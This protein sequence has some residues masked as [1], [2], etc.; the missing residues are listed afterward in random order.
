MIKEIML[1][2]DEEEICSINSG[3]QVCLSGK[4]FTARDAAHRRL[5][6]LLEA[7]KPLPFDFT[8]QTVFYAGPTPAKPGRITGSVGPTT[9]GRMDLYSPLFISKGL[10]IMIGKGNR[11]WEVIEAIVKYRGLYFAAIGGAAALMS[12]CVKSSKLIAF[13]DLGTE[14]I[15]ELLVEKLPLVAAI[16]SRGNNIYDALLPG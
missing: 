8:G 3:D 13:E 11:S 1:P 9:S 10:K 16:D 2:L 6:E 4:I 14:A 7:G 15:Y 12:K 5:A